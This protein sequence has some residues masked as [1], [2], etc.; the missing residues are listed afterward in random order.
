VVE[1]SLPEEKRVSV[2]DS[3][4]TGSWMRG[5]W[6]TTALWCSHALEEGTGEPSAYSRSADRLA[7]T[8]SV[9]GFVTL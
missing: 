7:M 8:H 9:H 5:P 6:M 2:L 1:R 4:Q 3:P